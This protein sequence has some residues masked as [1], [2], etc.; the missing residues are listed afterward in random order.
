MTRILS[1]LVPLG[2]LAACCAA[3]VQI[4][5]LVD[6]D[7]A[8][9]LWNYAIAAATALTGAG[10]TGFGYWRS[11]KSSSSPP[12]DRQLLAATD[13]LFEHFT[14]D[15]AAQEAVRIVARE[16]IERRYARAKGE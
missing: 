4:N 11:P 16:V 13:L 15:T 8:R 7:A 2:G 12:D 6:G 3:A 5:D 9:D 14:E 10:L 1:Q